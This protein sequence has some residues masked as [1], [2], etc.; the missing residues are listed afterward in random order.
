LH[1]AD[2]SIWNLK[3]VGYIFSIAIAFLGISA[4]VF[5]AWLERAGP[6]RAMFY[7]AMCFSTGFLISAAG[8][9]MH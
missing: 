1:R 3:E 5:G 7:T 6:R 4:A 2:G 9:Q 8:A